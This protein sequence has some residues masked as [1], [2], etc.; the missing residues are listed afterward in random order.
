MFVPA[1]RV[2]P[3]IAES[4]P[5]SSTAA[6]P[7]DPDLVQRLR[8]RDPDAF[9]RWVREESPAVHRLVSRLLGWQQD[10]DD[11]VQ[12]VFIVAWQKIGRF[13]GDSEIR[14]WLFGIAINQCR[15]QRRRQRKQ[16]LQIQQ[17]Q[18]EV[19]DSPTRGTPEPS[20]D[21]EQLQQAMNKLSQRDR[22]LIV[23]CGIQQ[24]PVDEA[25]RLLGAKKNT[26]EVRLHRARQRLKQ[27][28]QQQND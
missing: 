16:K 17:L 8:V 13:R 15:R 1:P 22:E 5:K 21:I 3:A 6:Q 26:V 23:V 19:V 14:T 25:A 10:C 4:I 24:V 7:A 18:Q 27:L 12:E 11:V 28:L 9:D 20:P 2:N